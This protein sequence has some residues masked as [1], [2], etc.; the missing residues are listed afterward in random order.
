[1]SRSVPSCPVCRTATW[2]SVWPGALR[3]RWC[4]ALLQVATGKIVAC[5]DLIRPVVR[6]PL[7][8]VGEEELRAILGEPTPE[9]AGVVRPEGWVHP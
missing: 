8:D 9:P 2:V 1:M 6:Q 5:G 4:G 3:C 7:E